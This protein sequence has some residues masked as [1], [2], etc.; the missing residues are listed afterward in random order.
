MES[1][2][3]L[4]EIW[5]NGEGGGH[6]ALFIQII[7]NKLLALTSARTPNV[8]KTTNPAKIE[9][10]EFPQAMSQASL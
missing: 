8:P 7:S 4:Y 5:S 2:T 10:M 1:I 3:I 6:S 9:V